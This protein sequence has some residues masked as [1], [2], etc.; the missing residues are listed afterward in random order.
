MKR[1]Q[2]EFLYNS[3]A[4]QVFSTHTK[5]LPRNMKV[6][7]WS[8]IACP[9]CY[10]GK[11]RFENALSKFEHRRQVEIQWRSFELNADLPKRKT[12]STLEFLTTHKGISDTQAKA[13][14]KQVTET[15]AKDGLKF[16]FDKGLHGN[17]F[18]GHRLVHFATEYG[19]GDAMK[20]RLFSGYFERGE[21]VA[22]IDTLISMAS[23]VGLDT[24][25]TRAMLESDQFSNAVRNDEAKA[26]E[27]GIHGVPFFVIDEKH[28]MS[29]IQAPETILQLLNKAWNS[30]NDTKSSTAGVTCSDDGCYRP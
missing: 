27:I 22:N 18:D 9:F 2:I 16:N 24:A 1:N 30:S 7:I 25:K 28:Q 5:N 10:I 15:A 26:R 14:F 4:F 11:R 21:S 12:T 20:E 3:F 6:E 19:C 13:L 8:D 29:G 17:T 23:D